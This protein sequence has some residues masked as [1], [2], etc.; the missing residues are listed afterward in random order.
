MHIMKALFYP[1][2]FHI[3][4]FDFFQ[5]PYQQRGISVPNTELV[6]KLIEEFC[7]YTKRGMIVYGTDKDGL[8]LDEVSNVGT[9]K[10]TLIE[11]NKVKDTIFT[12]PEDWGVRG[13][14]T[15]EIV[16]DKSD[17]R[18]KIILE[19]MIGKREDGYSDLLIINAAQYLFLNG[20]ANTFKKGTDLIKQSIADG[21]VKEELI[22]FVKSTDGNLLKIEKELANIQ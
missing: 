2:R 15:E 19:S 20:V 6:G 14:T 12:T 22:K 7:T 18:L 10:I 17:N 8:S 4:C 21:S 5:A 3:L 11:D 9:T 1:F 13:R 16:L